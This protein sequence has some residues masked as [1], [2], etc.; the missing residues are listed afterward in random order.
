MP[1]SNQVPLRK[2]EKDHTVVENVHLLDEFCRKR[3]ESTGELVQTTVGLNIKRVKTVDTQIPSVSGQ[4]SGKMIP[5][6]YW[7]WE[8]QLNSI[9]I[10]SI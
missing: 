3:P 9:L 8:N 4:D 10:S 2:E 5:T 1:P 6:F 7:L